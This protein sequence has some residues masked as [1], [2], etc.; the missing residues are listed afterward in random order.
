MHSMLVVDQLLVLGVP[1]IWIVVPV[2]AIVQ[3]L[4]A[5]FAMLAWFGC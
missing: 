3:L 5:W 2:A 1:T 4:F